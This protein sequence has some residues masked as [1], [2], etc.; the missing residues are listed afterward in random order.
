MR[1]EGDE[2][3]WTRVLKDDRQPRW[4][5]RKSAVHGASVSGVKSHTSSKCPST[6]A[7][8]ERGGYTAVPTPVVATPL[9]RGAGCSRPALP[10]R[11]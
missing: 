4:S 6:H 1:V 11:R 10:G 8:T 7:P 5:S 9:C 2:V 3:K